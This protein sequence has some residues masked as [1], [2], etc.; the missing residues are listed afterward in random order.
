MFGVFRSDGSFTGFSEPGNKNLSNFSL[1]LKPKNTVLFS[2]RMF[3]IKYTHKDKLN[4]W[5]KLQILFYYDPGTVY[6]FLNSV[7]RN[8]CCRMWLSVPDM[9]LLLTVSERWDCLFAL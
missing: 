3:V 7:F 4:F 1:L 8:M 6:Y 5:T 2:N 9:P